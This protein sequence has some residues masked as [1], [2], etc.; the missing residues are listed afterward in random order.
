MA[1]YTAIAAAAKSI[2]R[3]LTA[4]FAAD[5]PVPGGTTKARL[6]R[7]DD[8]DLNGQTVIAPPVLTIFLVRVEVNRVTRPGWSAVGSVEGRA[9]LPLDLHFL[10]TPWADNAEYEQRIL[11]SAMRCLEEVPVLSGPLLDTTNAPAWVPGDALQVIPGD[12]GPDGVMRIWDSLDAD[13]RLSV[14]YL[15]RIV[16]IDADA[17]PAGPPVLTAIAGATPSPEP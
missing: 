13:Y 9:L 12:I 8:F 15:A 7:S 1:G 2:E 14:P 6:V 16:R 5:A 17:Q 4:R 10:L 3:L 11:G